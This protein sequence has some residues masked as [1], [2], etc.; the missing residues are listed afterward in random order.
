MLVTLLEEMNEAYRHNKLRKT[1]SGLVPPILKAKLQK[2][3]VP[4]SADGSKGSGKSKFSGSISIDVALESALLSLGRCADLVRPAGRLTSQSVSQGQWRDAMHQLEQFLELMQRAC[5]P[6]RPLPA[7]QWG[8]LITIAGDSTHSS[9]AITDRTFSME[10][11]E[12]ELVD[13]P[14]DLSGLFDGDIGMDDS[15][16]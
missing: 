11:R 15:M 7:N 12:K 3:I 1:T 6:D 8:Q 16:E 13:D 4:G 5:D 9:H 10:D 14:I 2:T